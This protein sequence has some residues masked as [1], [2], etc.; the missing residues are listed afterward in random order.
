MQQLAELATRGDVDHARWELRYASRA[1]AVLVAERRGHDDRTPSLVAAAVHDAFVIDPRVAADARPLAERQFNDRLAA[2]R[3]EFRARTREPAA[4]RLARVLL[5]FAGA[6]RVARGQGLATISGL[7][8]RLL[9][10]TAAEFD[11]TLG[12]S[13]N[14]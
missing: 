5:V 9:D 10:H 13:A 4:T 6:V 14:A 12:V 8:A 3:D 2:Y 7:M 1:L 11:R